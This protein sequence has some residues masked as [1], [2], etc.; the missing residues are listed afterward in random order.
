MTRLS[1][2]C[3]IA[4]AASATARRAVTGL[5][6]T[7]T[8]RGRPARSMWESRRRSARGWGLDSI[9]SSGWAVRPP[10]CAVEPPERDL[11]A[12][13]ERIVGVGDDRE[14]VGGGEGRDDVTPLPAREV[15]G[16][17]ATAVTD[18]GA[19]LVTI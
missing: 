5:S 4:T 3:D 15:D 7:S 10:S 8:I 11:G 17:T 1:V 2:S 6:E 19:G 12:C 9:G 18:R 14:G 16:D 13:G